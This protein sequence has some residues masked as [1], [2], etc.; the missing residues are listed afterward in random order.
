MGR[1]HYLVTYDIADD[2]RHTRVF[3][4]LQDNG[5]HAQFSVFFCQLTLAERIALE[6]EVTGI[7]DCGEDQVLFVDLGKSEHELSV[8]VEAV[9]KAY[10]PPGRSMIV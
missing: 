6:A 9:G 10:D 7:I 4:M 2:K 1:R 5:D 3:N 8:H